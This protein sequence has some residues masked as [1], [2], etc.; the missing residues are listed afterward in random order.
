M[1]HHL[2]T[3]L[4]WQIPWEIVAVPWYAHTG[5]SQAENRNVR[6]PTQR[7][8]AVLRQAIEMLK[9]ESYVESY[10]NGGFDGQ[11]S[12]HDFYGVSCAVMPC[13]VFFPVG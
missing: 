4:C 8:F 5:K 11:G 1:L 7:M 2:S 3:N 9:D 10:T 6:I 12:G 13:F